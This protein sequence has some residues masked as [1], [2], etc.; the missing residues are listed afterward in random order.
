MAVAADD[1]ARILFVNADGRMALWS[2]DNSGSVRFEPRP[3]G[4]G[5]IVRVELEYYPPGG[6]IGA[7]FA[8]LFNRAP[9]QQ[10]Y[11]DLHRLKQVV[12]TGEIVRSDGSPEGTGQVMQR[13][14]QPLP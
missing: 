8:K 14:A 10:M 13:P 7:A 1:Q 6:V 11:D 4:R 9:E 5:T 3:G 12:E 2:V